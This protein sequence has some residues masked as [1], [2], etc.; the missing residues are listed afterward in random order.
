LIDLD[1]RKII[2]E[3]PTPGCIM[4]Y[5][6]GKRGFSSLCADGRFLST[7]LARDGSVVKQTRT[8]AF[9]DSDKS[10]IFDRPAVLGN[11]AYFPSLTGQVFPVDISGKVAKVGKPWDLVP[12]AER[13]KKWAPGG[14]GLIAGDDLGRFYV[15]MHT[16]AK[17]GS[18]QGGGSEVW[19]YDPAKKQRVLRIPLKAWAL[20]L[21]VSRG[22][23]PLLMIANPTDMS[24]EIYDG[25]SGE[26]VR[27]ITG[28]GQET[29][30]ML[31]G[32]R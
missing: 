14:M 4:A 26:F 8:A 2:N 19:V 3:I 12:E 22:K 13:V 10:P 31:Y 27:T 7:E 1:S 23:E 21:A 25:Q 15:L 5:P 32:S 18:Y 16:D 28:F 20:S 6:T 17:D 11:T 24:L 30:L 29:P 9:F